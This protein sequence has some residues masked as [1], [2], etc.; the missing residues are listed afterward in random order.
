MSRIESKAIYV[1]SFTAIALVG[2]FATALVLRPNDKVQQAVT[3]TAS[4]VFSTDRY[5]DARWSIQQ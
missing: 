2:F 1:A 4:S 3:T 5:V